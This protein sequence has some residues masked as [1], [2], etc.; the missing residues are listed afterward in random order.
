VNRAWCLES[1]G[2]LACSAVGFFA[3]AGIADAAGTP[4]SVTVVNNSFSSPKL[5]SSYR[6][7]TGTGIDGWT[8][9]GS[10]VDLYS[11][12]L[13]ARAD[14]RQCIDLNREYS[15]GGIQ[16]PITVTPGNVVT[17]T[18]EAT[19]SP[20]GSCNTYGPNSGAVPFTVSVDGGSAMTVNPRQ[21]ATARPPDWTSY[22]YTFVATKSSHTLAF[23][24]LPS[25]NGTCGAA[26][27]NIVA[28][29]VVP[30]VEP[31]PILNPGAGA[32]AIVA[33]GLAVRARSRRRAR[34]C[35]G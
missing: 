8:T 34:S 33:C 18:F 31:V 6:N 20:Y 15:P 25:T 23:T 4:Q 1:L 16:Q 26:V 7:V 5:A 9:I 32:F 11:G 14:G 2:V 17:V 19:R 27:S 21:R 12:S 30:D 10:G 29:Q 28:S 3:Q 35:R 13:C 24:S 22:T